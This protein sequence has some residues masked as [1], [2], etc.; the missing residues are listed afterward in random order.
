MNKVVK[1]ENEKLAATDFATAEE[2]KAD[3]IKR[4]EIKK[5]EGEKQSRI[6]S[7]EGEKQGLILE[8]EG[9]AKAIEVE[10]TAAEEYFT[11]NAQVLKSLETVTSALEHNTKIVLPTGKGL[12]NVIGDLSNMTP[13]PILEPVKDE[14]VKD[15]NEDDS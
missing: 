5:A 7:A 12:V 6:L 14:P 1:A 8:A 10:Y 15:E 3:G 4:A 2:T 11:G 13:L 9:K